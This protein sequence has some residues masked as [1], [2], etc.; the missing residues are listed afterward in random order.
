MPG[1]VK[2]TVMPGIE[3][4]CCR[5][6]RDRFSSDL[7]MHMR[8]EHGDE[9]W[10]SAILDAKDAGV[11]DVQIGRIL[12]VSFNA[13]SEMLL[14]KK[15]NGSFVGEGHKH[16]SSLEPKDF[17]LERTTVW[18]FRTRGSWAT[19]NGSYR[20]N[21]SPYIPRNVISRYSA[22]GDTVLDCFVGGG[23]TAVEALLLGR[24]FI[25]YDINPSSVA[26]SERAVGETREFAEKHGVP[27]RALTRIVAGD[28]RAL[29]ETGRRSADLICTHPPYAGMIKYSS[30]IAGDLSSLDED[31]YIDQMYEV[32]DEQSRV[33]RKGGKCAVLIGDRRKEKRVVPLGFRLLEI[34]LR[35][36]FQIDELVMK[37]QFNTR[38]WGLWYNKSVKERFLLLAHEYLPVFSPGISQLDMINTVVR[39]GKAS[40]GLKREVN[41]KGGMETTSVWKGK[42]RNALLF[43]LGR[44]AGAGHIYTVEEAGKLP[45]RGIH[46]PVFLDADWKSSTKAGIL[47]SRR[48]LTG[49]ASRLREIMEKG[50]L[51]GIRSRDV[52]IGGVLFPAG[53]LTWKDMQQIPGFRLK[54]IVML[55]E[56]REGQLPEDGLNLAISH[57]YLLIYEKN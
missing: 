2:K 42:D 47:K 7:G 57:S 5:I 21:W 52:R 28:A 17:A 55:D 56:R 1:S 18:S 4:G 46:C 29:S 36:G 9:A 48:R 22:S 54:E 10:R 41:L 37:R 31:D 32:I 39:P 14:E 19:H 27:L 53:L 34:Y 13:L 6:C 24:N 40:F 30:G 25:G 33:L 26:L 12:N 43:N 16:V 11:S 50:S 45:A 35:R 8:Q 15:G 20:G 44:L 3:D 49:I 51:L 23:T 38:T